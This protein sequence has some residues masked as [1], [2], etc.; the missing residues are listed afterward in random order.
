MD[1]LVTGRPSPRWGEEVV[2]VVQ[3]LDG[4]LATDADLLE[5]AARHVARYKLPKAVVRVPEV[6]RGPAGKADY[7]WAAR[8]AAHA[9]QHS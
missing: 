9:A 6:R 7:R 8:V 2:A 4:Q 3:L 5:E 1:C